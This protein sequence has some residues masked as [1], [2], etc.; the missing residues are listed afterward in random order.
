MLTQ[1]E[2]IE[3][4]KRAYKNKWTIWSILECWQGL[5]FD[6]IDDMRMSIIRLKN[7]RLAVDNPKLCWNEIYWHWCE[8]QYAA[9]DGRIEVAKSV[10]HDNIFR[11]ILAI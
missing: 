6:D 11:A 8:Y 5:G 2:K 3:L 10:S 1:R 9:I 4:L 7:D